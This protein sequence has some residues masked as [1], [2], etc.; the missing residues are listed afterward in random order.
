[1]SAALVLKVDVDTYRGTLEGVP[2]LLD[3]FAKEGVRATFLFSL[4]PDNTG[5]AVK[6][7]LKKG[8]VKKVLSASPAASYGFATMLYGTLLPA[9]DIGAKPDAV[10]RMREVKAA[11]H[12]CGIHGWD[13]VDW[14]DRLPAMSREEIAATFARAAARFEK[15]FGMRACTAGA[16]GWTANALSVE[17]YESN[18]IKVSSDSRGGGPFHPLRPD[19]TASKVL[20]IPTTL[21]TLDELLALPLPGAGSQVEKACEILRMRKREGEEKATDAATDLVD[22]HSIHTEIEGGPAFCGSF[23]R[24]LSGW[25][26]DGVR[27]LTFEELC[28]TLRSTGTSPVR[29]LTYTMIP[30]R[31]TPVA[32]G[33]EGA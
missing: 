29:R 8:F 16:P 31:A 10:R 22:V 6:R 20:E 15:V 27:V 13:H 7:V 9:P 1:M 3:L 5:K 24:L 17:A 21:P 4:G 2:R 12:E 23:A 11:G 19:G 26:S 33:G 18:G 32:T 14:H 25:K 30:G 28:R